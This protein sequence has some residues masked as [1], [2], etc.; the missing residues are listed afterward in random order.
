MGGRSADGW[1]TPV[2]KHANAG[3]NGAAQETLYF[4]RI[5]RTIELPEW[6]VSITVTD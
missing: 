1:A 3:Q 4:E 6:G 5:S 2:R